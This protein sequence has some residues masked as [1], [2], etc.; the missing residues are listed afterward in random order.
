M[1]CPDSANISRQSVGI[2]PL[3]APQSVGYVIC[4]TPEKPTKNRF[5]GKA[6]VASFG[7]AKACAAALEDLYGYRVSLHGVEKWMERDSLPAS[8]L[9]V[10]MANNPGFD[11]RT[12]L[13]TEG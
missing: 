5:S 13:V 12:L 10:V 8:V 4:M 1:I 11:P 3:A 6:F 9:A 7:G 2:N